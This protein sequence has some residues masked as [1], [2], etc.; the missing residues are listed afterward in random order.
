MGH[1]RVSFARFATLGVIS[2]KAVAVQ[3]V[4]NNTPLALFGKR[5]IVIVL[6]TAV[7]TYM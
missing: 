4:N 7:E 5:R 3:F 6:W 2:R 1:R